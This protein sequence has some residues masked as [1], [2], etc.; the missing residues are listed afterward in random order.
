MIDRNHRLALTK[1]SALGGISRGSVYYE[2][3]P[4][5][6]AD[7]A[8]MRRLDELHLEFPFAGSRILRGMSLFR[9]HRDGLRRRVDRQAQRASSRRLRQADTVAKVHAGEPLPRPPR[10]SR[11]TPQQSGPRSCRSSDGGVSLQ[12]GSQRDPVVSK[13][14]LYARP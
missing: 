6:D 10:Q 14:Q 4:V 2:P 3:A 5:P 7:L 1:Q 13:R 12:S 11:R 9:H 8:L